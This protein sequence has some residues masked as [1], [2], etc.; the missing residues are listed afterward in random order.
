M[1][2]V[3]GMFG[4]GCLVGVVVLLVVDDVGGLFLFRQSGRMVRIGGR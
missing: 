3:D 4:V 1:G 2:S